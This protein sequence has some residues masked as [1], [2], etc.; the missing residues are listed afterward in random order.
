MYDEIIYSWCF[1]FVEC[2]DSTPFSAIIF[3]VDI[4]NNFSSL[5]SLREKFMNNEREGNK[6]GN[7]EKGE[8]EIMKEER[9]RLG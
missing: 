1:N 3:V 9:E 6:K 5:R 7:I 2:F 8:S 4:L